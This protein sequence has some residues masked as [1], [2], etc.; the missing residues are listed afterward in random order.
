G[1]EIS[2]SVSGTADVLRISMGEQN[3]FDAIDATAVQERLQ[4][5][6]V[7][8]LA[9]TIDQPIVI[10]RADV[11]GTAGSFIENGD[12]N[13]RL[14]FSE[15]RQVNMAARQHGKEMDEAEDSARHQPVGIIEENREPGGNRRG[16]KR[17]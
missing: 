17:Q 15:S 11:R 2:D 7:T 12:R 16:D 4:R 3:S 10:I 9:T 8:T 13:R 6:F 14:A 5:V 1:R